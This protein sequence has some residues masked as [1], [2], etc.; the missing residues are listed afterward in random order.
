M[1]AEFLSN[2][3]SPMNEPE[4]SQ[5][6]TT[7]IQIAIVDF[8]KSVDVVPAAVVGHSSGE[9]AAAYVFFHDDVPE[10]NCRL[11]TVQVSLAM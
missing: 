5:T 1:N 7:A 10:A 3:K 2:P 9:I 11:D 4:H 8:L 6:V